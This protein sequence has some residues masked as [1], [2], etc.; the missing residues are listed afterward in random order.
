VGPV[1]AI[2][3]GDAYKIARTQVA[4]H[5]AYGYTVY[6]SIECHLADHNFR[7]LAADRAT[8]KLGE[9]MEAG[10]ER[11]QVERKKKAA[12]SGK[13]ADLSR[14]LGVTPKARCEASGQHGARA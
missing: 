4:E 5:N 12:V 3:G 8:I 1:P 13:V 6:R 2:D 11:A 7:Q 10:M 14:K 9:D